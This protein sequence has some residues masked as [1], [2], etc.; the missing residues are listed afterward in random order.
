MCEVGTLRDIAKTRA[1]ELP[2]GAGRT[3]SSKT[4]MSHPKREFLAGTTRVGAGYGHA[5]R[6]RYHRMYLSTVTALQTPLPTL[7]RCIRMWSNDVPLGTERPNEDRQRVGCPN[8]K[9]LCTSLHTI[10]SSLCVAI[11]Y[12]SNT[13]PPG[14]ANRP[15]PCLIA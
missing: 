13:T 9:P 10:C 7:A 3:N 6:F 2:V 1:L 4:Q 14:T 15:T 11:F 5:P 8:T 12:T